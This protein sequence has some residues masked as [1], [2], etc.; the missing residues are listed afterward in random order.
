MTVIKARRGS[1]QPHSD[2][3]NPSEPSGERVLILT[4]HEEFFAEAKGVLVRVLDGVAFD[5]VVD[6]T[7]LEREMARSLPLAVIVDLLGDPSEETMTYL[8]R[9]AF[10]TSPAPSI[11]GVIDPA[12][13]L[14]LEVAPLVDSVAAH[15]ATRPL[16]TSLPVIF[17]NQAMTARR[18]PAAPRSLTGKSI[19]FETREPELAEVLEDVRMVAAHD[20]TV[21]LVGETGSGKTTLARLFHELSSRSS[22]PFMHVACGALP[23]TLIESELFGH[24]KGA[25]T[26]ADRMKAG[27]FEAAGEGTLLLDEIDALTL[28]QQV[29]LLRVIET[30]EFEPVGSNETNVFRA[31]LIVASNVCLETLVDNQRFRSDLYY[32]LNV[33]KFHLLPLR[34]R[35]RDIVPLALQFV[36]AAARKCGV[37]IKHVHPDFIEALKRYHWPGNLR[38]L[39]N[40]MERSVVLCRSGALALNCLPASV[41]NPPA[42]SRPPE[43][44]ER[45]MVPMTPS[46]G[47]MAASAERLGEKVATSEKAIIAEV[48]RRHG[49][50][51]G[52]A[53]R[54]LGVSRVTLYNKMKKYGMISRPRQA[55]ASTSNA[56]GA[57]ENQG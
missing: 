11:I 43:S 36:D 26:G 53:A 7:I 13:G 37:A 52:P 20:V 27:K 56:A 8:Q 41:L 14:P 2:P 35:P 40:C 54:E 16:R 10:S 57:G 19:T 47:V 15:F 31:R 42:A 5:W 1:P 32:R 34:D 17:G 50:R 12:G 29:K 33:L 48:L 51:R 55:R 28:E 39:S 22:Q 38:E 4:R 18:I 6:P 45:T 3:I 25:F 44:I 23:P 46:H 21:L 30:R 49:E 24:V 9:M